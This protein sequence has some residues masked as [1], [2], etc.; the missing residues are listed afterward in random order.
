MKKNIYKFIRTVKI[1]DYLMEEAKLKLIV[2]S[3]GISLDEARMVLELGEGDV[4]RA[5]DMV[6]YVEKSNLI[7]HG[8]FSLGRNIKLYGLFRLVAQ[9]REATMLDFGL[10]MSYDQNEFNSPLFV[11]PEAFKKIIDESFKKN[12]VTQIHSFLAGFYEHIGAS[13]ISQMYYLI[14]EDQNQDLIVLFENLIEK[15]GGGNERLEVELKTFLM[16]RF[17]CEK[18]GLL[19]P[20]NTITEADSSDSNLT[21]YLETEPIIS[22]LKGKTIDKFEV[23]ELIPL[24]I[25]DNGE[26]GMYQR[27][28]MSDESGLTLGMIKDIDFNEVTNRYH[29][30]VEFRPKINGRF[31]VDSSVRL[32]T[33]SDINSGVSKG[34]KVSFPE[35][36]LNNLFIGLGIVAIIMI[37]LILTR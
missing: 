35:L 14:K 12:E 1:G 13:Q 23:D 20:E 30:T 31:M 26:V 27:K 32:A 19:E 11:T 4:D 22:P 37:L 5:L 24:K 21:I 10:A 8:K 16:T 33:Y 15:I 6:P 9:G 34:D 17:Q 28:M 2:E 3:S 18:K 25:T 36:K 29:V 7:I